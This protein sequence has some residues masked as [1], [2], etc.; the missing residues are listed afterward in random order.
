MN[1]ELER[2]FAAYDGVASRAEALAHVPE[3]VLDY[4]A[5]AGRIAR[6]FPRTYVDSARIAEPWTRVRAALRYVGTGAVL[7]HR[8]ALRVW[9]LPGGDV[10]GP[11]H[12]LVPASRRPRAVAGI[13]IH[14]RRGFDP[15]GP[16]AVIRGGVPT[17]RVE[18]SVI[19]SWRLLSGDARRAAVI[20]AVG[21]RLTTPGRLIAA[22]GANLN[23]PDRYDLLRLVN[24]LDQGCRSELELWGYDNVFQG[25]DMP[26]V[27]RNVRVRVGGRSVYLDVYCPGAQVNFE[28]DGAKWHASVAARERDLRRDALLATIG[29][30]VVRFTHDQLTRT[31]EL[32]RAQVQAIV[33][34]RLPTATT[35]AV[36]MSAKWR[37]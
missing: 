15:A 23:V 22:I 30:T 32:V 29:I 36:A 9:R 14:R 24:L 31:P 26:H 13:V 3:H 19:D 4:A 17:C 18:T 25:P 10:E 27:E 2:L 20:R 34:A 33:G 11:V 12:V 28:L 6:P 1:T 21:D 5:R 7:S 35:A 16:D 8:T 37:W